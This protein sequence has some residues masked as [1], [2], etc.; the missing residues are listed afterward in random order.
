MADKLVATVDRHEGYGGGAV[1]KKNVR[2]QKEK[3]EALNDRHL[4]RFTLFVEQRPQPL[5]LPV[6]TFAGFR[7]SFRGLQRYHG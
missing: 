2:K 3:F 7:I 4:P 6:G 5:S 1:G